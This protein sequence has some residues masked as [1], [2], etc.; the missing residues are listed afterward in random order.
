MLKPCSYAPHNDD[1]DGEDGDDGDEV[2]KS[3]V[4]NDDNGVMVN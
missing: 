1:G 2:D 4:Q 3:H